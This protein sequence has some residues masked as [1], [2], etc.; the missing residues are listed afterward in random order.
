MKTAII[1]IIGILCLIYYGVIVGYAGTGS[2]F[3]WFWLLAG[4]FCVALYILIRYLARKNISLPGP[5][6]YVIAGFIVIGIGIFL[7]VECLII[8]HANKK[9]DPHMDYLIV[10]GAQIR[11]TRITNSLYK[12]LKTAEAYLKENPDTRVIVSGGRGPGEDIPEAHAMRDFLTENGIGADRIL[13]EDKSANTVENI[14]YS[15]KLIKAYDTKVAVVTNE[16]HIF[17][18]TKIAEKQGLVNIQGLSAPS[19]PILFINYYVREV[20]GVIKDY[21][22]GNM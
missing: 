17:R 2:S 13:V 5:V 20:M 19:D 10:L 12:R 11:G 9:A 1:L 16:F 18:A 15:K 8:F 7:F 22:F 3:A 4:I 14:L 21:L 6:R